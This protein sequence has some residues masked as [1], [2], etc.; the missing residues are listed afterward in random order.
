MAQSLSRRNRRAVSSRVA[1]PARIR[2]PA[3]AIPSALRPTVPTHCPAPPSNHCLVSRRYEPDVTLNAGPR[4]MRVVVD[5]NGPSGDAGN[6]N[7][8]R[9]TSKSV[10]PGSTRICRLHRPFRAA[11]KPSSSTTA[12]AASRITMPQRE[13]L[14]AHCAI[15][16]SISSAPWKA[17]TTLGGWR[18]ANGCCTP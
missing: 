6:V 5:T 7:F 14:A 8:L 12:E 17:T 16:P 9:L 18:P 2:F 4:T 15:P 3:K 13:T 10:P 1:G 11:S